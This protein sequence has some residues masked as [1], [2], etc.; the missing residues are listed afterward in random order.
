M[1]RSLTQKPQENVYR[2]VAVSIVCE[3]RWVSQ[4]MYMIV[5]AYVDE[6]KEL[7]NLQNDVYNFQKWNHNKKTDNKQEQD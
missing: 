6:S 4:N 3:W 2:S 5:A 1:D 7:K